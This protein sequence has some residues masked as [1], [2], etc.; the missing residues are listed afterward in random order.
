MTWGLA[1]PAHGQL[2][3]CNRME[4]TL[5]IAV[6]FPVS[7]E[8]VSCGWYQAVSGE[9]I[10]AISSLT[11]RYYYVHFPNTTDARRD[12]VSRG[13][14][15]DTYFCVTRK[16]FSILDH[17]DCASR[18]YER[19]GF[20]KVDTGRY[21]T[22]RLDL[23]SSAQARTGILTLRRGVRNSLMYSGTKVLTL[24]NVKSY[25]VSFDLRCYKRNGFSKTLRVNVPAWGRAE[26]GFVQGWSGNFVSGERCE[27]HHDGDVVWTYTIS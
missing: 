18:G 24:R 17:G 13:W 4:E 11:N 6:G 21:R 7:G 9:C 14:D 8:W 5:N 20:S 3:L 2:R 19:R 15:A 25:A 12:N 26:V 10:T 16:A 27:A 22:Y 1:L 23:T